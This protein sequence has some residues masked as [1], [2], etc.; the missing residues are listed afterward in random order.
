MDLRG[1][2]VIS[3]D[4][5]LYP[6]GDVGRMVPDSFQIF[7]NHNQI[8]LI[9][10]I[11]KLSGRI[12]WKQFEKFLEESHMRKL[13]AAILNA[14][15]DYLHLNLSM[16]PKGLVNKSVRPEILMEDMFTGGIYGFGENNDRKLAGFSAVAIDSGESKWKRI[17]FPSRIR[18]GSRYPKLREKPFLYPCYI[19]RRWWELF[20][21]YGT[22]R[23]KR[24]L[25]KKRM[26][27]ARKRDK[28]L[29]YYR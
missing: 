20:G 29:K 10:G 22:G 26:T 8:D 23:E 3:G 15:T 4:G 25:L 11:Q 14:G 1:N 17:L 18:L 5:K 2:A 19:L 12:D 27:I 28:V 9:L 21:E 24:K 13:F 16:V 6:L 7:S